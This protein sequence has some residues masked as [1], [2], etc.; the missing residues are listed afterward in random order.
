MLVNYESINHP[1]RRK[2]Y[3]LHI[4][5]CQIQSCFLHGPVKRQVANIR[6]KY[7]VT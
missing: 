1:S 5:Q 4:H 7:M 3:P 2:W 6:T